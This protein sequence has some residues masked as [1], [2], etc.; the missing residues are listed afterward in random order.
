MRRGGG[1]FGRMKFSELM[2]SAYLNP[3]ACGAGLGLGLF[4]AVWW[5][6]RRS[7]GFALLMLGLAWVLCH[8]VVNGNSYLFPPKES[9]DWLVFASSGL[10]PVAVVS[11]LRQRG[12]GVA[13]VC[14]AVLLGAAAWLALHKLSWLLERGESAWQRQLWTAGIVAAVLAAFAAGEAA[15]RKAPAGAV[16]GALAAFAALGAFSLLQMAMPERITARLFAVAGL[17]AGVTA[18]ALVLQLRRRPVGTLPPGMAG[19]MAGGV[20]LLFILGCLSR[21]SGVPLLPMAAAGMALPLAVV[22]LYTGHRL[23][24]GSGRIFSAALVLAGAALVWLA[25]KDVNRP[26]ATPAATAPTGADDTGAYD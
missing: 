15:A 6:A 25:M 1:Q 11:W 18:P 9:A 26:A 12:E 17:A 3:A 5:Q 24:G 14:A 2:Q 8:L 13:A 10:V 16:T 19:W 4:L 7:G 23:L 20:V 22:V 21:A